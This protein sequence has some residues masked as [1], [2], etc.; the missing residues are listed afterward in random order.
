MLVRCLYASRVAAPMP[1][2]ALDQI[3][4]QSHRNNPRRGITGLLCSANGVFVQVL[5]GGRDEV[6]DLYN[7]IVRDDRHSQVRMLVYEEIAERRFGNWSMGQVDVK[8]VNPSLLLK[9]SKTADIDPFA[10]T[11]QAT[12]ALLTELAAAGSITRRV[13]V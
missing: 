3:L 2:A 1:A 11:G 7:A 8:A 9:Y 5:E 13:S 4:E 6:C 10:V 12:M